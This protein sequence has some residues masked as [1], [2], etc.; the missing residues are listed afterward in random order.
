MKKQTNKKLNLIGY[1]QS[2]A[3]Y[4]DILI[5]TRVSPVAVTSRSDVHTV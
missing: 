1:V 5:H 3:A 2:G 4:D